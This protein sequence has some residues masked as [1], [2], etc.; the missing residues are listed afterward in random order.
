MRDA[1]LKYSVKHPV[2]NDDKMIVWRNL[3][4]RSWP[5]LM[6]INPK[7]VPILILSGEGN[8]QTL[9]LVLNVAY[10][11][12]ETKLNHDDTIPILDENERIYEYPVY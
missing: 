6:I 4:R 8:R 1:I 12:Y 7:G 3:E 9:D 10:K 2:I 5:S 11:H